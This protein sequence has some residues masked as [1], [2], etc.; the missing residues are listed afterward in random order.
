MY[1]YMCLIKIILRNA[2]QA[3]GFSS[4]SEAILLIK[5]FQDILHRPM[6]G[7]VLRS[8]KTS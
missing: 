1:S 3:I 8:V 4:T 2:A 6:E 5:E 7:V